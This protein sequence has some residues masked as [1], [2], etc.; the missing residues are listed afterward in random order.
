METHPFAYL[1]APREINSSVLSQSTAT[2]WSAWERAQPAAASS[3]QHRHRTKR[4]SMEKDNLFISIPGRKVSARAAQLLTETEGRS[5]LATW[6]RLPSVGSCSFPQLTRFKTEGSTLLYTEG[7]PSPGLQGNLNCNQVHRPLGFR[8]RHCNNLAPPNEK[9]KYGPKS[10]ALQNSTAALVSQT[11][12]LCKRLQHKYN[13]DFNLY[14]V[15]E[16]GFFQLLLSCIHVLP[17]I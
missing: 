6:G 8:E 16:F 7:L 3:L 12:Q 1:T 14:T 4:C 10:Q 17:T 5:C 15:G 13:S 2:C 11:L 9:D